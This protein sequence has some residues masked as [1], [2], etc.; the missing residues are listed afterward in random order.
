MNP[1]KNQNF[2]LENVDF[3][4]FILWRFFSKIQNYPLYFIVLAQDAFVQGV[5]FPNMFG[6][7]VTLTVTYILT[8]CRV[9]RLNLTYEQ[10]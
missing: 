10:Y 8:I 9:Y 6:E 3:F 7:L 4:F 1:R 5:V 2:F